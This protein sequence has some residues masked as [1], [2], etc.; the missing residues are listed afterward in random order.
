MH[1]RRLTPTRQQ[2]RWTVLVLLSIVLSI[3]FDATGVPAA[4]LL[5]PM[6]AAIL[7][8]LSGSDVSVPRLGFVG[9]QGVI[10]CLIARGV[11]VSILSTL[12]EHWLVFIVGVLAVTVLANALGWAL[13]HWNVLPGDTAVW[14]SAPGAASAMMIMAEAHGSDVRLVAF[15]QYLR[16][17]CVSFTASLVAHWWMRSSGAAPAAAVSASLL[18]PPGDWGGLL[19]TLAVALGGAVIGARLR[20][21][22]GGLL[23]PMLA[24]FVLQD[25]AH[26]HIELPPLML[27]VAYAFVGW[28]IGMRFNREVLR[29]T[30][31]SLPQ[32][33]AA[34]FLLIL[35]CGAFAAALVRWAHVD[36]LTA[37]LATSPGGAD[38][39]AIIAASTP[40]DVPF[41][42]TM[43]VLRMLFVMATGPTIARTLASHLHR[44]KHRV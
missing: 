28:T 34:I 23:L 35:A 12:S 22:A 38:S 43:Q 40:V 25:F 15:M 31:K 44:R 36:P 10:G 16:V 1:R 27:A 24:G 42:L 17:V 3:A 5:G 29:V 37:Y 33:L 26:I 20:L 32:V 18:Q 6:V 19:A 30:L 11:P 8:A 41:V 39:V 4:R 2:L 13:S 7:M 9:A 21:P 14:G